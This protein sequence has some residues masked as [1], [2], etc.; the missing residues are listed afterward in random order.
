MLDL[1]ETRLTAHGHAVFID[2]QMTVGT[3]WSQE[4]KRQVRAADAVIPLLSAE[5]IWSERLED[6]VK[7]AHEAAQQQSGK[8]RILP[9]RLRYTDPLPEPL[10]AILDSIHYTLWEGPQDDERIVTELLEEL[11][12]PP[13][14]RP[15]GPASGA[16][17]PD[18]PFYILRPADAAFTSALMDRDGLVLIKGARQTGKTSLLAR[19]LERVR[20]AGMRVVVTDL[21]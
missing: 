1:L 11:R 16:I 12:R 15:R 2:R 18:S 9:V 7:A 13:T 8:P 14:R 10:G 21:Q 3:E 17:P 19:G 5:S 20:E 4:V 6:E